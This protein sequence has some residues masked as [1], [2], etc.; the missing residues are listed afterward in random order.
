MVIY[1]V[2]IHAAEGFPISRDPPEGGTI[3][4]TSPKAPR[5]ISWFPIS[6]DPPEGGT[7]PTITLAI[8]RSMFPISRDPPEGGT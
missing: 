7:L 2:T 3:N 8:L 5:I 4:L 6:R 1:A